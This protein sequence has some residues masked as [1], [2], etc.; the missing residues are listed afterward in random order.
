MTFY[1]FPEW[2]ELVKL[3]FYHH[4]GE[5]ALEYRNEADWKKIWNDGVRPRDA[6]WRVHKAGKQV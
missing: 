5:Q 6:I 3:K 2:F 4:I 1:T